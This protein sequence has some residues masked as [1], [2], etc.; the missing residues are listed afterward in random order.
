MIISGEL[1]C[2]L[3]IGGTTE[4]CLIHKL[5]PLICSIFSCSAI[6]LYGPVRLYLVLMHYRVVRVVV[7]H[8]CFPSFDN[9]GWQY[10]VV[11]GIYMYYEKWPVVGLKW[12]RVLYPFAFFLRPWFHLNSTTQNLRRCCLISKVMIWLVY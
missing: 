10:L 2:K 12:N 11:F 5:V 7:W 6:M 4:F 1:A 8:W 3:V 9:L